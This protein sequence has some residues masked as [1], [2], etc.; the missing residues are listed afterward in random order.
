MTA[1]HRSPA[2]DN[3]RPTI[4]LMGETSRGGRS[5]ILISSDDPTHLQRLKERTH[6]ANSK[7]TITFEGLIHFR[8]ATVALQRAAEGYAAAA[9]FTEPAESREMLAHMGRTIMLMWHEMEDLLHAAGHCSGETA[10][11]VM[12]VG[13]CE[14]L[15]T[16]EQAMLAAERAYTHVLREAGY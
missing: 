16:I 9:K 13:E 6:F 7:T 10:I 11:M 2:D 14:N 4:D 12:D 15:D 1:I 3:D 5:H 8:S